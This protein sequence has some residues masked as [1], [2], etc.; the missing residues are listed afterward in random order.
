MERE[1]LLRIHSEQRYDGEEPDRN[2]LM[3]RGTLSVDG[4]CFRISYEESELTGLQGTTTHFSISPQRIVLTR[5]GRLTSEMI[6]S[7]GEET[8]SLYD[9]GFGALLITVRTKRIL[10]DL[11][12]EGGTLEVHYDLL[13]EDSAVGQ[14]HYLI[15]VVP[16]S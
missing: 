3:S 1:V 10:C 14:V 9:M 15:E 4:D 2:E 13:V 8:R 12:A 11:S 7:T 16:L 5:E 6:F